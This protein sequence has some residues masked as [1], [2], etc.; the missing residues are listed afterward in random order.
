M[1]TP[2]ICRCDGIGRRS[3]LKI[4]RWRQ[5]T[6]SSPVTGTSSSQAPYRLRRVFSFYS[7]THRALILLLLASKS[8]PLRWAS[9]WFRVQAWELEHL[10]CCDVPHRGKLCIACSDFFQK[11]ERAHAAA[12]PFQITTACAGLRFGFGNVCRK[13][14]AFILLRCSRSL[15]APRRL[16]RVFHFENCCLSIGLL[17]PSG[18][19]PSPGTC[20]RTLAVEGGIDP[21]MTN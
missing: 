3:G 11:P 16:Q 15:Q 2:L 12:P 5:R 10:S 6:G 14:T 1:I 19:K 8:N 20:R 9:I 4:H 7:K 13:A 18:R 21:C 17:L